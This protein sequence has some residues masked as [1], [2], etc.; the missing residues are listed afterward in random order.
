[1]NFV[2]SLNTF[3]QPGRKNPL[4]AGGWN[5]QS[6]QKNKKRRTSES[7]FPFFLKTEIFMMRPSL[8]PG[9]EAGRMQKAGI[10]HFLFVLAGARAKFFARILTRGNS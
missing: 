3:E 5:F 1:M 6:E 7:S 10:G 8:R 4:K 9:A 2:F